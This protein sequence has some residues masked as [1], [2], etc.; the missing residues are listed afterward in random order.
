[1]LLIL[2]QLK[3]ICRLLTSLNAAIAVAKLALLSCL[4]CLPVAASGIA[5]LWPFQ[6]DSE[7]T[8]KI[9]NRIEMNELSASTRYFA[10]GPQFKTNQRWN[11]ANFLKQI[12]QQ[13]YRLRDGAQSL[14]AGDAKKLELTECL[15]LLPSKHQAQIAGQSFYCW[16]WQNHRNEN[17]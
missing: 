1:M 6:T 8:H 2:T 3:T 17:Y 10:R 13:N 15:S 11:E 5:D 16:I 9:E 14:L 4:F 7:S 12:E